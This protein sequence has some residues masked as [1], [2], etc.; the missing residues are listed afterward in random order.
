V[1][2]RYSLGYIL[3]GIVALAL[4]ATPLWYGH[5]ANLGTFRAYVPGAEM[6]RLTGVFRRTGSGTLVG[7]VSGLE[8]G[9]SMRVVVS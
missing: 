9:Q 7:L 4:F 5:Q 6:Q 3:L 8:V 1:N 2:S